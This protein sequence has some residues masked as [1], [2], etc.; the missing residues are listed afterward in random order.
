MRILYSIRDRDTQRRS[1]GR[2]TALK[3]AA[4]DPSKVELTL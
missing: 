2:R 1:N 4:K 3:Q